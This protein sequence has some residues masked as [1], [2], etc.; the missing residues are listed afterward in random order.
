M[1]AVMVEVLN[2]LGRARWRQRLDT[3]PATIGRS[4]ACTVI[5]DERD[6]S[7]THARVVRGED[8][9]LA[10]EDAG[11]SNGIH[12]GKTRVPRVVLSKRTEV[13]LGTVRLRFL[14]AD[15]PVEKTYVG[16]APRSSQWALLAVFSVPLL[17]TQP[18]IERAVAYAWAPNVAQQIYSGLMLGVVAAGWAFTWAVSTHTFQGT[19]RFVEHLAITALA[20]LG[21]S[22]MSG[23]VLPVL[24]FAFD[25]PRAATVVSQVIGGLI[26]AAMLGAHI[27]RVTSLGPWKSRAIGLGVAGT[28]AVIFV[29]QQIAEEQKPSSELPISGVVMP[30]GWLLPQGQG[31]DALFSQLDALREDVDALREDR[32]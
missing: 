28:M 12:V 9:T 21:M 11:S 5:V 22:L 29:V 6:I 27:T 17:V 23:I 2:R 19:L 26:V 24:G 3:F 25:A 8:G 14:S 4:P 15:A 20:L 7:A 16:P 13:R 10:V 18:L 30:P 1:E 31:P 32:R